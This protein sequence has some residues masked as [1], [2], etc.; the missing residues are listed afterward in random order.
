METKKLERFLFAS[1]GW[2]DGARR[3]TVVRMGDDRPALICLYP[4]DSRERGI[5]RK[6]RPGLSLIRG[7]RGALAD[8]LGP[9][10]AAAVLIWIV[11]WDVIFTL[12]THW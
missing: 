5:L 11:I 4:A 12:L 8:S 3:P 10:I 9:I 1:G 6:Y 7:E 2:R